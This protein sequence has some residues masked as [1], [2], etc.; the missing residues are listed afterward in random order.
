M[1]RQRDIPF[2]P[3]EGTFG[4]FVPKA[5][6]TGIDCRVEVQMGLK[7]RTVCGRGVFGRGKSLESKS[8]RAKV[9]VVRERDWTLMNR[10]QGD[11]RC[12]SEQTGCKS[13]AVRTH[14]MLSVFLR[15]EDYNQT[16][17]SHTID[18]HIGDLAECGRLWFR[19]ADDVSRLQYHAMKKYHVS[20]IRLFTP[21]TQVTAGLNFTSFGMTA[22][23][24]I[25][26]ADFSRRCNEL[27]YADEGWECVKVGFFF[28]TDLNHDKQKNS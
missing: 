23:P 24:T 13:F 22:S 16:H 4:C 6:Y 25:K 14:A 11:R 20:R 15:Y 2:D 10:K 28:R 26:H 27:G 19:K 5:S 1:T 3:L 12:V 7:Q 8:H 21:W 17:E 18:R 9:F